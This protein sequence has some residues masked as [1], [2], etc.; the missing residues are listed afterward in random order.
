MK[1]K[2][3]KMHGL[4]N[5]FMVIDAQ[6]QQDFVL[7]KDK[8]KALA[9]RCTGIGF[10]QLLVLESPPKNINTDFFYRIYNADGEQV[11]QCGNGARCIARYVKEKKLCGRDKFVLATISGL[12]DAVVTNDFENITV[13]LGC[14]QFYPQKIPFN[15]EHLAKEYIL[16][17]YE[18]EVRIMAVSMGNP[19]AVLLVDDVDNYPVQSL[20][21]KITQHE[22]FPEGVNVGFMEIVDKNH[23]KLRV[24]ERGCGETLACG[25]GAC[26][27]VVVGI[28]NKLLINKV[29]VTLPGGELQIQWDGSWEQRD[30]TVKMTGAAVSVF[31]GEI[32]E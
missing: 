23:I 27:A 9:H 13:T 30:K 2:F 29:R 20:G 28:V 15:A 31:D 3:T 25:S 16:Q 32:V 19:H 6:H 1:I 21:M 8:I 7:T 14:P 18:T 12:I 24:Y 22:D 11:Q 26:A 5:D 17:L 4:G 10:D